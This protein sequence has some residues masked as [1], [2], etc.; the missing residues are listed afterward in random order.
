MIISYSW[1]ISQG[2]GKINIEI[3]SPIKVKTK[4]VPQVPQSETAKIVVTNNDTKPRSFL[5]N[6][7]ALN[8]VEYNHN[9]KEL[10]SLGDSVLD[11]LLYS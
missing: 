9:S 11:L 10:T 3:Y 8:I 5:K 1:S 6:L 4:N 2:L 7:L